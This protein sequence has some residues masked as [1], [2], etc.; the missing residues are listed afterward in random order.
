MAEVKPIAEAKVR[1]SL[2]VEEC[3]TLL[4]FIQLAPEMDQLADEI[5]AA[6]IIIENS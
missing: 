1:F 2:S 4:R 3:E 6:I 5:K